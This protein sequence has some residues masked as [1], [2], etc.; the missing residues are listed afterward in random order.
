APTSFPCTPWMR[1]T[2][3]LD[4]TTRFVCAP[5]KRAWGLTSMLSGWIL[6][7]YPCPQGMVLWL[8][9][10]EGKRR[11][12]IDRSFTP[13]F[14]VHGPE[15]RLIP[16]AQVLAARAAVKCALTEKTNIWD[17]GELRVLEVAVRHPIQFAALE[18]R[19]GK[20]APSRVV[21][22]NG[23]LT[24]SCLRFRSCGCGWKVSPM[25]TR[26]MAGG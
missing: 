6:D 15:S 19:P 18:S 5:S 13:C 2:W 3:P 10:P 24:M 26:S 25:L 4:L 16:L 17:G 23:R 14:Y 11:R 1:S 22:T 8:V 7:L 20:V 21:M 9:E 12:L